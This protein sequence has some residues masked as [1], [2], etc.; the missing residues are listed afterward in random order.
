R[1][2]HL[3]NSSRVAGG[4]TTHTPARLAENFRGKTGRFSSRKLHRS[5]PISRST[6][7]EHRMPS[8][9]IIVIGTSAGG[10][11]AL[12]QIVR[13]LPENLAA[14]I[15]IV[16]HVSPESKSILLSELRRIG[17]LPATNAQDGQEIQLGNIY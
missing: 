5:L 16:W 1:R 4:F 13:D 15:F 8:H 3:T 14:A 7:L 9:D 11:H 12:K 2:R 17:K 10:M 6:R